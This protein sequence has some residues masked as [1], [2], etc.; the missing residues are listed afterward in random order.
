LFQDRVRGTIRLDVSQARLRALV[1]SAGQVLDEQLLDDGS[2][3][4]QV[5]FERRDFEQ[6]HSREDLSFYEEPGKQQ[7]S[8]ASI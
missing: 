1:Y 4:L 6:L 7:T 5:E 2:W 3:Q 8:I